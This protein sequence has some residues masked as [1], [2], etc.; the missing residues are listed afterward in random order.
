[1]PHARPL[2]LVVA[3]VI[4]AAAFAV[5]PA[6]G[7]SARHAAPETE[8]A[9]QWYDL[10]AQAVSA[11]AYPEPVTQSRAWA[12]SWL[13]AAR[14]VGP[15]RSPRFGVPA[16]ATAL[17]D[18]LATLVPADTA[19]LD[20]ALA[21]TLAAVPD[22]NA[23]EAGIAAGRREAAAALA[24]RTGDGLDSAAVDRAWTPPPAGP[25]IWQPTPPSF[26]PAIRAGEG[27]A[28]PYVLQSPSQFRPPPPP[29]LDSPVYLRSLAE[30]R[31]FGSAT[32]SLRTAQQTDD[33]RFWLQNSIDAYVQVLRGVL[34]QSQR[35]LG[36]DARV[37]GAFHAV[38][39]DAQIAVYDAKY[40][41]V[42]WRP[43]T[44]IRTTEPNWTPFAS[45]PRHPEYPSGHSGY[46]GAAE[47]VL[48]RLVGRPAAPVA[49]TSSADPGSTHVYDAWS[50]ITNENID[51]RVWEGIHF[52]FSDEAGARLGATV[53]RYDL[54]RLGRLGIAVREG[55]H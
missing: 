45:T 11:A 29:A 5:L 25:G 54:A 23:K 50:Q 22:G 32:G 20:D 15:D 2:R 12:V 30:V 33:A 6:R 37:I 47:V 10:T 42:F 36:W 8:I 51:G 28:L 31:D 53:A 18:T 1:M 48:D 14:A 39:I 43:V 35:T 7:D 44:A 55:G 4:F 38:T 27:A 9:L 17:H 40:A 13:A 16:F 26:G 49:V 46:A 24:E 52:R 21:T 41:Y 19:H 3:L 34:A